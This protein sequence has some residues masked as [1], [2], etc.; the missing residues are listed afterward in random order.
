MLRLQR[1]GDLVSRGE[2]SVFTGQELFD[3]YRTQ[4]PLNPFVFTQLREIDIRSEKTYMIIEQRSIYRLVNHSIPELSIY[5]DHR[6]QRFDGSWFPDVYVLETSLSPAQLFDKPLAKPQSPLVKNR[7]SFLVLNSPEELELFLLGPGP[8]TEMGVILPG[9]DSY[10]P[11]RFVDK[12]TDIW[13]RG[14]EVVELEPE[15]VLEEN[16]RYLIAGNLPAELYNGTIAPLSSVFYS[17]A[18]IFLGAILL[19]LGITYDETFYNWIVAGVAVIFFAPFGWSHPVLTG[20]I[21]AGFLR[22]GWR[23]G[24]RAYGWYLLA[25]MLGTG[26]IYY[27]YRFA[28]LLGS[29]ELLIGLVVGAVLF[30]WPKADWSEQ[31]LYLEDLIF[32][33][34]L[35]LIIPG[36][37]YL[38]ELFPALPEG[39]RLIAVIFLPVLG[40]FFSVE[41]KKR[42]FLKLLAVAG[43]LGLLSFGAPARLIFLFVAAVI[44]WSLE[45]LYL[46]PKFG[47]A[48]E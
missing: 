12:L 42:D 37:I 46:N 28:P 36:F 24:S 27:P 31:P 23:R 7:S 44:F 20:V 25:G 4:L 1:L 3:F 32:F 18:F 22:L 10:Y 17:L 40:W 48:A 13:R 19:L 34:L 43:W 33:V 16:Q 2:V 8:E 26:L 21:M 45:Q 15:T 41:G 11:D 30:F 5:R 47:R 6:G 39:G 14:V 35:L 29:E 9:P 38:P